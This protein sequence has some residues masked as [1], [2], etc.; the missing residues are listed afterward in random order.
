MESRRAGE[1]E[2]RERAQYELHQQEIAVARDTERFKA[3]QEIG[4]AHV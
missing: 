3:A 1:K 2:R 4:R